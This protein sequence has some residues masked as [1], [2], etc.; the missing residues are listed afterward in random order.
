MSGD[1]KE[2]LLNP[3]HEPKNL[4][5]DVPGPDAPGFLRRQNTLI[6]FMHQF[7]EA[8]RTTK[9]PPDLIKDMVAFLLTFVSVPKD[10]KEAEEILW[11][12]SQN[13]YMYVMQ[14]IQR[15][16][17]LVPRTSESPSEPTT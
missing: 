11:D 17:D 5:F 15:G 6:Q 2:E 3:E 14:A 4:E 10:R 9:F 1:K 16:G 7:E 12:L 8:E 13:Q